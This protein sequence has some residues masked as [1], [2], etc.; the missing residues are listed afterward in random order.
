MGAMA[1]QITSLTIVYSTV[2]SGADQ[3][4]HKLRITGHCEG[5]SPGNS[6]HKEPVTQKTVSFDDVIMDHPIEDQKIFHT[7]HK[8][9]CP[10]TPFA[11]MGFLPNT[12]PLV[13]DHSTCV[14]HVPWCK[15]GSLTR[16][17]GEKVPGA[18]AAR[19]FTYLIRGPW[20]NFN[21]RMV[22]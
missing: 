1:S 18:G 7:I 9:T 13:S 12:Q 21:P 4:K 8:C 19:N 16:G 6:S 17:G 15:S 14:T 2:Y 20:I 22:K 3:R 11:N 10:R 5:N